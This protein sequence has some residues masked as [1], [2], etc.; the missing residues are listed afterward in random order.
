M[1]PIDKNLSWMGPGLLTVSSPSHILM[2]RTVRSMRRERKKVSPCQPS[3]LRSYSGEG[4][5]VL[6]L[7]HRFF[8]WALAVISL[9]PLLGS[10]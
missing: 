2:M 6:T 7:D 5:E 9:L 10:P 3:N 1:L 8:L 4:A